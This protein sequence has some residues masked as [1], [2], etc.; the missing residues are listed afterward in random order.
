MNGGDMNI[1]DKYM[2]LNQWRLKNAC[3]LLDTLKNGN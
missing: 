1:E 2:Q 3:S